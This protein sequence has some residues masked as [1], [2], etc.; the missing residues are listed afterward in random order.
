MN[1]LGSDFIHLFI[2]L[3]TISH[4]DHFVSLI[5]KIITRVPPRNYLKYEYYLFVVQSIFFVGGT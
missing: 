1:T 5:K 2:L 4:Q 3:K